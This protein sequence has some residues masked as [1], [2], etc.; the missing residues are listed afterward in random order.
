MGALAAGLFTM[1]MLAYLFGAA[2]W[3]TGLIRALRKQAIPL[4]F[5]GRW[6]ERLPVR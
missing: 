1:V 3:L 2:A 6:A 4:P 5:F